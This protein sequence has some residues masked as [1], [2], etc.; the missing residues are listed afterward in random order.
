MVLEHAR[1]KRGQ[2]QQREHRRDRRTSGDKRADGRPEPNP[3][4]LG[5]AK[6]R[7][8]RPESGTAEQDQD[9]RDEREPGKKHARDGDR[10][11]DADVVIERKRGQRECQRRQEHDASA[12]EDRLGHGT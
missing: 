9:P 4:L 5:V 11:G 10:E 6:A 8:G 1:C 7:D 2:E 12:R 3:R